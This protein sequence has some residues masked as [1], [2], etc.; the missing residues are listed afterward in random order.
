MINQTVCKRETRLFE[1]SL[2]KTLKRIF[3]EWSPCNSMCHWILYIQDPRN[4]E[5][6]SWGPAT[7]VAVAGFRLQDIVNHR[8]L[9]NFQKQQSVSDIDRLLILSGAETLCFYQILYGNDS[10]F[11]RLT[12]LIPE[13]MK[14]IVFCIVY[15]GRIMSGRLPNRSRR[16]PAV[17]S[18]SVFP[19]IL[20]LNS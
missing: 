13:C 3:A 14:C 10:R 5:A 2:A 6:S 15:S 1:K 16:L 8:L 19:I 7:P 17:Q 12:G 18:Y 11:I 4:S 9:K 20:I